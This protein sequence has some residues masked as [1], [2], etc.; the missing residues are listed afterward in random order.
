VG[1]TEDPR[2]ILQSRIAYWNPF[3]RI[4][5]EISLGELHRRVDLTGGEARRYMMAPNALFLK[6][7]IEG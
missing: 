3:E 5:R 1:I 6:R 7:G 4:F 2:D